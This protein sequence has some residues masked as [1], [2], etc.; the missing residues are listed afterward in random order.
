MV[1]SGTRQAGMPDSGYPTQPST[2]NVI[3][4]VDNELIQAMDLTVPLLTQLGG[5]NQFTVYARKHYWTEDD[6]WRRRITSWSSIADS[7]VTALT[8]TSQAHRYP[9]GTILRVE[10]ELMRV[11]AIPD[12][13][14]LTVTRGYAGSTP[15][16]HTDTTKVITVSGSSMHE[17]DNW[18]YRPTPQISMPYNYVQMDHTAL[19]ETWARRDMQYYGRTGA[20]EMADNVASTLAQKIV[21]IEGSLISGQRFAG[22]SAEP[23][24]AGGVEYF[25]TS[26]NGAYV[27][28]KSTAALQLSDI[29][30]MIH[31]IVDKVGVENVGR[32]IIVDRWGKEKISSFFAGSRR[33]TSE[34]RVGQSIIDVLR[35]E[36]GDFKIFMHYSLPAGNLYLLNENNIKVG[37]FGSM[38][39][40]HVGEVL[41]TEG[42]F[43]GMYYYSDITFKVKNVPTMG[44]IYG[45]SQSS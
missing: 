22:E 5:L 13:N 3:M 41:Q 30:T 26:A 33:L 25:V 35:T 36:W 7:S 24:T 16:A 43:K 1:M 18:V 11:T 32:T 19:R 40:P 9:I 34:D 28:N 12:A 38:G 44:R 6:L 17:G 29:Y 15:A 8:I 42:P 21:A 27:S 45:Y 23:A 2:D 20:Q 39:N 10:D 31:T 37:T 4:Q 14:T